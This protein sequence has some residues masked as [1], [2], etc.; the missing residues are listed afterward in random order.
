MTDIA[1]YAHLIVGARVDH[2][3]G[4]AI[5]V[6]FFP[7]PPDRKTL[8]RM[9]FNVV[10]TMERVLVDVDAAKDG[11]AQVPKEP[12]LFFFERGPNNQTTFIA[13]LEPD[14]SI[15]SVKKED[16]GPCHVIPRLCGSQA[17]RLIPKPTGPQLA[18][19][20]K[21][22]TKPAGQNGQRLRR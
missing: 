8:T 17:E 2:F 11:A 15:G 18:D 10:Q 21:L 1:Q 20:K 22:G 19:A 9:G 14:G 16:L 7:D 3:K 6:A 4:A 5:G 13:K 12:T